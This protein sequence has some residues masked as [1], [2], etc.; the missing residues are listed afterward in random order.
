MAL[1][2][3]TV[4][5]LFTDIEGSTRLL[6]EL[7]AAFG[8]VIGRHN[9]ILDQ[10][11]AS[12]GGVV[13]RVDGDAF[14][15]AFERAPDAV[16]A[17]VDAQ[18]GLAE[19]P[20]PATVRVRMGIHTG[21][22]VLGGGDYVGLDV[23]RAARIAA[24]GH[25][26]QVLLSGTTRALVDGRLPDGVAARSLGEHRLK[27]LSWLEEI[28]DLVVPG[29]PADFAPI[30]T[31]EPPITLPRYRTAFVGRD[32]EGEELDRL[33]HP[34]SLVTLTG[35]GGI[36]KTRLAVE[37]AA[38]AHDRFVDGVHFVDL[39]PI[40]ETALV[41]PTIAAVLGLSEVAGA[42]ASETLREH[43]RDRTML[44]LLDNF[45]QVA[46]AASTVG[47]LCSAAPHLSFLITS[48][49]PL[50][51]SGE[52]RYPLSGMAA[53]GG[54]AVVLF[55]D[56]ARSANPRFVP[57]GVES[58]TIARI[59]AHLDGLPL[60]IELAASR[61]AVTTLVALEVELQQRLG[62]SL[63]GP[64]DTPDRQRTLRD[65]I[66]WSHDL[67]D[68]DERVVFRRL[69]VFVGGW[70]APAVAAV[71]DPGA[72][73]VVMEALVEK[74]LVRPP[75]AAGRYGML[76]TIREFAAE[77]LTDDPEAG[78]LRARHARFFADRA[79]EAQPHL[80]GV[81]HRTWI[82]FLYRDIDNVRAALAW[83]VEAGD[84]TTG[85]RLA[86][87][88]WS[89]WRM[90]GW[91]REGRQ[92]TEQVL[93]IPSTEGP[94]PLRA[95]TLGALGSLSYW[96]GDADATHFAYREAL[97]MARATGDA[98]LIAA[99][100]HD[101]SYGAA[102]SGD[103]DRA[104]ELMNESVEM[105]R[106]VGDRAGRGRVLLSLGAMITHRGDPAE[107]QRLI[108]EGLPLVHEAGDLHWE[109]YGLGER[110][111]TAYDLGDTTAA[112][113]GLLQSAEISVELNDL[114]SLSVTVE[115]LGVVALLEGK[116]ERAIRLAG[117]AHAIRESLGVPGPSQILDLPDVR[118][119][120][121]RSLAAD[122]VD[123][124]WAEGTALGAEDALEYARDD[125]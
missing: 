42:S 17:A 99:A 75:D 107:G 15:A 62:A 39:S 77:R 24:A 28:N 117:A 1:P 32:R 120:A 9:H 123:A 18:R 49:E 12:H 21:D 106:L 108:D 85:M 92:W 5:F 100:T 94:S 43:L 34:G 122:V 3:G 101:M 7:G 51:I 54:D 60:A 89:F 25:G 111:R 31:L 19:E 88:S 14:F 115:V 26:G 6:Q 64:R 84:G 116:P 86:A 37:A 23:H 109:A 47:D 61:L 4:T 59:C 65:A 46:A 81:E 125:D 53:E 40:S 82:D 13:V 97:D 91:A 118:A 96:L 103:M 35:P 16:A 74:S 98:A 124:L 93:A 30:R 50:G 10:A 104:S 87:A 78:S 73:L 63:R 114:G 29:L 45:E 20:W 57:D 110:A 55:L 105:F 90:Q 27:D 58:A 79:E 8:E 102:M 95:R 71:L 69:A 121:R 36:G 72:G 48:R 66:A 80:G 22:G 70:D 83:S 112:R 52:Q 44:L 2:T 68:E 119:E 41:A 67:L 38:T 76:E 56:R 11:I 113:T 33:L